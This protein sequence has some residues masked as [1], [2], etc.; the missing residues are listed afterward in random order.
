MAQ[1]IVAYDVGTSGTKTVLLDIEGNIRAKAF[2]PYHTTFPKPGWAEQE[3][4][5]WWRA[6]TNSTRLLLDSTGVSP[7]EVLCITFSTQ[8]INIVPLSADGEVLRRAII[9]IDNRAG[10]QAERIMKKFINASIFSFIA[11]ATLSGKDGLPKLLWLKE[12]EPHIYERM[13]YFLDVAGYLFYRSTGNIAMEWSGASVFGIDLKKKVWLKDLFRYIGLDSKKFPPLVRSIDT[14]GNLTAEAARQIGLLEGTPVVAGAGDAPCALVGSGAVG[15]GEGHVCL[16]TSGWVGVTTRHIYRGKS[17]VATIQSADPD[18]VFLIAETEAAG[19]CLQWLGDEVY[20][21]ERKNLGIPGVY[22]FM[23][24]EVVK[25]PPGSN[26]VLFTPW[27]YGERAPVNDCYVRAAF[28]NLSGEHKRENLL[29][30]VYEGVAFNIRWLIEI[31]ERDFKIRLPQL[32]LIGGGAKS[33]PWM[34]ILA[35][36]TKRNI[37]TICYPQEAGAVG[38][39][40]VAMVGLG[41]HPNFESLKKVVKLDSVFKPLAENAE[42]YD[43]LFRCYKQVYQNLR[44]FYKRLNKSRFDKPT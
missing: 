24:K 28:F 35:D 10:E 16:G 26:Y 39:A 2:E 7:K 11:G 21:T 5:D 3:P 8:M 14:V 42:V 31:V 15:E 27:I 6:V 13:S 18:K 20:R 4:D 30:A 19:A 17:G 44:D 12:E 23:D 36:V 29:R 1:Y 32:R 25:V 40:L 34:Q 33:K 43:S 38:A 22:V 37:E 9:W 41:I